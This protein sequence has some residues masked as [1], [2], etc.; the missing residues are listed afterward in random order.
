[1]FLMIFYDYRDEKGLMTRQ[2][3]LGLFIFGQEMP[4]FEKLVCKIIPKHK[5]LNFFHFCS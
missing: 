5:D 3:A 1:M 2:R 4:P